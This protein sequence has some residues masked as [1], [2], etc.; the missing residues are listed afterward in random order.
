MQASSHQLC[1]ALSDPRFTATQ[2]HAVCVFVCF[3]AH[4]VWMFLFTC[5]CMS[6][7]VCVD[8]CMCCLHGCMFVSVNSVCVFCVC[9]AH[10]QK[11]SVEKT[12][13]TCVSRE[14]C[15][16][17]R[18]LLSKYSSVYGPP[19]ELGSSTQTDQTDT[20]YTVTDMI[21]YGML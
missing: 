9:D 18:V 5:T 4:G 6:L 1:L 13:N 15:H 3:L 7:R 20:Q 14:Q 16:L 17:L 21:V 8:S 19:K 10:M 11:K 2:G 12:H